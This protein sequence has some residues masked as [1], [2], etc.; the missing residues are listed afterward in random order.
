MHTFFF[1]LK[2]KAKLFITQLFA[3]I[4]TY[5]FYT[6]EANLKNTSSELSN[7]NFKLAPNTFL[8]I[9]MCYPCACSTFINNSK[10]KLS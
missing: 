1:N 4:K 8:K 7:F 2:T 5:L 6:Q 3:K 9:S 10:D